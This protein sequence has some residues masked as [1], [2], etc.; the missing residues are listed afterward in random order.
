M[1]VG[2]A[3]R[4]VKP[5]GVDQNPTCGLHVQKKSRFVMSP[6]PSLFVCPVVVASVGWLGGGGWGVDMCLGHFLGLVVSGVKQKNVQYEG[7]VVTVLQSS[8]VL[9]PS[10]GVDEVPLTVF[11]VCF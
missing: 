7:S 6:S 3:V 11:T 5:E 8:R 1:C 9:W 4:S 2:T 10:W